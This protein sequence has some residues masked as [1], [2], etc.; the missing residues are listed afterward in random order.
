MKFYA[1]RSLTEMFEAGN[2]FTEYE[3]CVA[4]CSLAA[5]LFHLHKEGV[6]HAD[7]ALR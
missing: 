2:K 6:I 7:I 5:G 3:Q 1:D 4:L